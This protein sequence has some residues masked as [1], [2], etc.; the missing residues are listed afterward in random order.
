VGNRFR[1]TVGD[2]PAA[3]RIEYLRSRRTIR[4]VAPGASASATV[5]DGGG[6]P[7]HVVELPLGDFCERLGIEPAAL[8]PPRQYLLFAGDGPPAG[9]SGDLA[10]VFG[11]PRVAESAFLRARLAHPSA[12]PAWGELVALDAGG[13]VERTRWFGPTTSRPGGAGDRPTVDDLAAPRAR[14]RLRLLLNPTGVAA[15][16]KPARGR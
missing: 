3:V 6:Q 2:G 4:V 8:V 1:L 16:R 5:G 15:R 9:G 11:D 7:S 10:G 13:R 12:G 14:R